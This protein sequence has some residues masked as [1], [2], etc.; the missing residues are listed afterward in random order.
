MQPEHENL[1]TIAASGASAIVASKGINRL[2]LVVAV[3]GGIRAA[4][5]ACESNC[6]RAAS[7]CSSGTRA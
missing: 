5:G 1:E 3:A 2:F 6:K 4:A 7:I